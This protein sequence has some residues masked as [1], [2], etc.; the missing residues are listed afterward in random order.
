MT[1]FSGDRIFFDVH[2]GGPMTLQVIS[3]ANLSEGAK[4]DT[5]SRRDA[6]TVILYGHDVSPIL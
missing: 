5:S 6:D 4:S 3:A 2:L 1:L